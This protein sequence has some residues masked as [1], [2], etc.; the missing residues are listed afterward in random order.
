MCD[1]TGKVDKVS[2][3]NL[4][5]FRAFSLAF[6]F[7]GLQYLYVGRWFLF[8]LQFVTFALFTAIV[9]LL[10]PNGAIVTYAARFCLAGSDA[11]S[12][13]LQIELL[14][15]LL[16]VLNLLIGMFAIK[17]DKQGG[18]LS[19]DYKHGWFWTFFVLFGFTGAH[20]AY[21]KSRFLLGVH[22]I[23][24]SCPTMFILLCSRDI[25]SFDEFTQLVV[26]G[27]GAGFIAAFLEVVLLA[28]VGKVKGI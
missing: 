18:L 11:T 15:G 27:I 14:F 6:G 20:L 23:F 22:L 10:D 16:L 1:G 19:D 7:S 26:A 3:C 17:R 28:I 5:L 9:L 21:I 13:K 24:V 25:S 2:K 12:V 8:L 4:R